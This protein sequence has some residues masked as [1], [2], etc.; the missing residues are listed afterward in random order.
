MDH[1]LVP[2][3]CV[4][5]SF[6]VLFVCQFR[7]D[8]RMLESGYES[9]SFFSHTCFFINAKPTISTHFHRYQTTVV[10]ENHIVQPIEQQMIFRTNRRVPKVC[11]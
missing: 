11:V 1:S 8:L 10:H 3:P 9:P 2:F 7:C 4:C 6:D 5:V